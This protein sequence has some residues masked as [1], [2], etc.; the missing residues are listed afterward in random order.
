[1]AAPDRPQTTRIFHLKF[2]GLPVPAAASNP[3]AIH[4]IHDLNPLF[5]DGWQ[6]K[7]VNYE[8]QSALLILEKT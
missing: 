1:M 2:T 5:L 6:V 4:E 3:V 7:S 8:Q